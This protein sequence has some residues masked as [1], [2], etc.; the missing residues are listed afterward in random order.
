MPVKLLPMHMQSAESLHQRSQAHRSFL[1]ETVEHSFL[2]VHS[3]ERIA[4]A[5]YK[6]I[7]FKPGTPE[8]I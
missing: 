7:N 5:A 4:V 6:D 2:L 3:L 1:L 8:H